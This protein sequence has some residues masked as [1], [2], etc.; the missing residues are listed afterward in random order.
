MPITKY[1]SNSITAILNYCNWKVTY[2]IPLS[3]IKYNNNI[4]I[5]STIF[6]WLKIVSDS[7]FD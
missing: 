2:N 7:Y 3:D 6:Q 4:I 5:Y 1:L